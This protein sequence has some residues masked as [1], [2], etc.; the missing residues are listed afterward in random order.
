[1]ERRTLRFKDLNEAIAEIHRLK[2]GG[3]EQ[4]GRWSLGENLDHL[5]RTMQMA[6]DGPP[7]KLPAPLR[8]ILR[9]LLLPKMKRGD[10]IRFKAKAPPALQPANDLQIDEGVRQFES[11]AAQIMDSNTQLSPVHPV[12]GRISA[13]DWRAMLTWHAAHHLSFLVP[14]GG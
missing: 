7:F 4:A 10:I 12:F 5:N 14:T 8:P 1:M 2:D 6:I 9:W 3:Y 11:L 13:D